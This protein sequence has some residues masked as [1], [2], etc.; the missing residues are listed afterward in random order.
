M[1]VRLPAAANG[2]GE[3][4]QWVVLVSEP[5]ESITKPLDAMGGRFFLNGVLAIVIVVVVLAG[6]VTLL[7]FRVLPSGLLVDEEA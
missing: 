2:K 6:V 1:R 3:E 5:F 7:M 4:T